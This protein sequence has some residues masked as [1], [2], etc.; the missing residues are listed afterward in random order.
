LGSVVI[1][2]YAGE[3]TS[4]VDRALR[5]TRIS[6]DNLK[7]C[8]NLEQNNQNFYVKIGKNQGLH[9]LWREF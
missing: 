1:Q 8:Q 3:C 7:F 6:V 9:A 5:D 2:L 4:S